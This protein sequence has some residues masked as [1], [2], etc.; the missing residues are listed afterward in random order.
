MSRIG[1]KPIDLGDKTTAE[2]SGN[3]FTVKGPNGSISKTFKDDIAIKIEGKTITL[4]PKHKT[5]E[6]I[7]LWGT[8]GSHISNMIEGVNTP[9]SQKLV[10]EGIGYKAD[11]KGDK[12]V[13][14]LG[15]SHQITVPIP[16]GLTLKTDKN[17]ITITG[18]DKEKVSQFAA[19]VRSLKKP[20]P[21]K[22]KGIMYEGERIRR[23]QGKKTV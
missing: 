10:I 2:M 17:T 16:Q 3:V 14:G 23:K 12:I 15:F 6:T 22:G 21:Y 11:I 5:L 19:Y 9:F 13:F 4:E 20:E 1:K 18:V 7:A 8:Y